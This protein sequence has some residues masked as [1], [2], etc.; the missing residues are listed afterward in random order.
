MKEVIL[1]SQYLPNL[2]YLSEIVKADRVWIEAQ[3]NYQKQSYRNRCY[4][5]TANG[6]DRLTVPVL[7]SGKIPIQQI[8]IDYRQKWQNRHWRAIQSAYAHAPFFE[9]FKDDFANLIY[10]NEPLLF[11]LNHELLATCLRLLGSKAELRP[12]EAY[13]AHYEGDLI[14][15]KRDAFHPK[16]EI[17]V[18][19]PS[20][21]QTFGED[22][23][24][25]LSILDL[26]FCEG[27]QASSTLRQLEWK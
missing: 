12:T 13:Q 3:E 19:I 1:T 16:K 10:S 17:Q 20:Y 14:E 23:E 24:P 6:I 21:I 27:P 25:N 8:E 22:F 26:L 9:F 11:K 15:D 2:A 7:H 18:D 5:L 4:I